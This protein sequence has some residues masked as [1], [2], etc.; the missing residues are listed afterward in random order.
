MGWRPVIGDVSDFGGLEQ[1]EAKVW[2]KHTLRRVKGIADDLVKQA[3][4]AILRRKQPANEQLCNGSTSTRSS[5][6]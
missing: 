3:R 5:F 1:A 6:H 2:P 4:N